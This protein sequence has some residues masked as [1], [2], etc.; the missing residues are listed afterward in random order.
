MK[1]FEVG[2]TYY[3]QSVMNLNHLIE[4]TVTARTACTIT[5]TIF[6]ETHTYRI[7]KR[8][9]EN[10]DAETIVCKETATMMKDGRSQMSATFIAE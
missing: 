5:A 10:N 4:M 1:Q 2:K 6:G 9:S 3:T 7:N 8:Y